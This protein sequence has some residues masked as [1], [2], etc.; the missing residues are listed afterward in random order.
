MGAIACV[1][2]TCTAVVAVYY[3][4]PSDGRL[5]RQKHVCETLMALYG[6]SHSHLAAAAASHSSSASSAL[7]ADAGPGGFAGSQQGLDGCITQVL[8]QAVCLPGLAWHLVRTAGLLPWLS[9]IAAQQLQLLP[10]EVLSTPAAAVC[11]AAGSAA[12]GLGAFSET[13]WASACL[14]QLLQSRIGMSYS[15]KQQQQQ[16]GDVFAAYS[17]AVLYV[18]AAALRPQAAGVGIAW[19]AVVAS[20]WSSSGGSSSGLPVHVLLQVLHLLIVLL[21]S[22]P[23]ARAARHVKQQLQCGPWQ[24]L[25]AAVQAVCVRRDGSQSDVEASSVVQLWQQLSSLVL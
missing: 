18:A 5:Y 2:P 16:S 11:A 24:Q 17:Q 9:S 19:V 1:H 25:T 21:Q 7:A 23:S 14:Q 10:A 3:Q 15:L 22:A 12:R 20:R 4:V 13:P 6:T 8:R